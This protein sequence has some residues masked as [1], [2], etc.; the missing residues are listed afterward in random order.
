MERFY[1]N[2]GPTK[3]RWSQ[4]VAER[5]S[6]SGKQFRPSSA[7]ERKKG[8]DQTRE[9]LGQPND[10]QLLQKTFDPTK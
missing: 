3:I 5:H 6:M 1:Q 8:V 10:L 7:R 9:K 4:P 2:D